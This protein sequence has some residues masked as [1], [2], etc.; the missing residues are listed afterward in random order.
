VSKAFATDSARRA[1]SKGGGL[2]VP[3][4]V[5][6]AA[7]W[8]L[9]AAGAGAASLTQAYGADLVT[10][11][12]LTTV[13]A[14]VYAAMQL[15][16]GT[17]VDRFGA[18]PIALAGL[19]LVVLAYLAAAV[20]PD[21]TVA[22]V[23]RAI[24]GAGSAVGFVAGAEIA[25]TSGAGPAGLGLFGGA[26]I[27][28]GG[29]AVAV[30]PLLEPLLGWRSAWLS[31]AAVAVL[32]ILALALSRPTPRP[33][34]RAVAAAGSPSV[35]LDHELHRLSAIH[36][37]TLGLGV[38]LS[39]WASIILQQAWGFG[40]GTAA[41][42]AALILAT[43]IVSRPLGGHLIRKRP[44]WLPAVIKVSLVSC[45]LCCVALA[46]PSTPTLVLLALVALGTLSGLPFAGVLAA[47]QARRPDRPATAVGLMNAYAN[48]L[49]VAG[50]PLLG[51]A[52]QGS[53]VTVGL[54]VVAAIWLL[55]YVALPTSLG[56][57]APHSARPRPR[58]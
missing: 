21:L 36:A 41:A 29:I 3:C 27:G 55:P 51:A 13:L 45:A 30:V 10:I 23:A 53:R 50:T 39:N 38:V 28:S 46:F 34:G 17:L 7:G 5:G 12:L 44:E 35:L 18:R 57:S 19:T 11:G 32:A 43:T 25:R 52:I 4:L 20:A 14:V 8:G 26:A 1:G 9:T 56:R 2:V 47:A 33:P 24:A 31:C 22:F 6:G 42:L 58:S 48:A 54:L 49:I 15:P 40:A 37:V 16:A